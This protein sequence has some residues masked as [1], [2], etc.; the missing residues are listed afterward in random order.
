MLFS[1]Q[2]FS[3]IWPNAECG[4]S[5]VSYMVYLSWAYFIAVCQF[6]FWCQCMIVLFRVSV[7][8][9]L[10]VSVGQCFLVLVYGSTFGVC[11]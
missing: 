7:Y 3:L 5:G 9:A 2:E 6:F 1:A 8:S 11:V 10:G 4:V